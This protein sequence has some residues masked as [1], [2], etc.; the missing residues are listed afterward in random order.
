LLA[1]PRLATNIPTVVAPKASCRSVQAGQI[2]LRPN[3][4]PEEFKAAGLTIET[5]TEIACM[6]IKAVLKAG[7]CKPADLTKVTVFLSD[8]G[9]FGR[10]NNV[11]KKH[12]V[13]AGFAPPAR[14]AFAVAALPL[15]ALV[16]IE[17]M[18]AIP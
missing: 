4:S 17:A 10:M 8:I 1:P 9:D 14:S 2:G 13:D 18:A 11:Y 16:E 3:Q 5:Q 12:F 7:G 6:N 15:G